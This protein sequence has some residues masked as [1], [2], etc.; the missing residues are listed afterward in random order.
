MN[1]SKYAAQ[2]AQDN[3]HKRYSRF[4]LLVVMPCVIVGIFGVHYLDKAVDLEPKS[5]RPENIACMSIYGYTAEQ[6]AATI[7]TIDNTKP[8]CDLEKTFEESNQ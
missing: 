1:H 8:I 3:W 6:I 2:E 7:D 4:K 5:Y